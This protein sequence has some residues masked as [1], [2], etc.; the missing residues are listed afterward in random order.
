MIAATKV[1]C[2]TVV[3]E[4]RAPILPFTAVSTVPNRASTSLTAATKVPFAVV[5]SDPRA[6]STPVARV[7][8]VLTA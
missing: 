3:S 4:V 6:P 5:V 2:A 1:P 7:V 8:S